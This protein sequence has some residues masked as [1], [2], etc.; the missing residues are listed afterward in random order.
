MPVIWHLWD[1]GHWWPDDATT[2]IVKFFKEQ[3][4]PEDKEHS[5]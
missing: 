5:K 4:L 1:G 2:N 3:A